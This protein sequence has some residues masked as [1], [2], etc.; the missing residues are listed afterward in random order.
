MSLFR[1]ITIVTIPVLIQLFY[2]SDSLFIGCL[3]T[4]CVL[5][6]FFY[7]IFPRISN[8]FSLSEMVLYL[9]WMLL[10]LFLVFQEATI[11]ATR[12]SATIVILS[13][14]LTAIVLSFYS[15]VPFVQSHPWVIYSFI[16]AGASIEIGC[17]S[18]IIQEPFISWFLQWF[19]KISS[20]FTLER[21]WMLV[22]WATCLIA[23][24]S[25]VS[26]RF[27]TSQPVIVQ[28]KYFQYLSVI[29]FLPCTLL[30]P[31]FMELVLSTIF[32]CR[33][34][35]AFALLVLLLLE[36]ARIVS[37]PPF[38]WVDG[39]MKQYVDERDQGPLILTHFS[40]LFGCAL[41]LWITPSS[42]L[43]CQLAGI[44]SLGIGDSTVFSV[45]LSNS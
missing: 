22:Y 30:D 37:I 19:F 12:V 45:M 43:W 9:K 15:F 33:V 1:R 44:S 28:R 16:V 24:F 35:F 11:V 40:L 8:C 14:S 13:V 18:Y 23:A 34:A 25:F 42:D 17:L 6:L 36:I 32:Y 31:Q 41:P 4:G 39:F 10:L 26:N 27:I 20:G 3:L 7:R 2:K 21:F 5:N 38:Q 29:L